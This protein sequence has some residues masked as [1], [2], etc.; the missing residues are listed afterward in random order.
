MT[1]ALATAGSTSSQGMCTLPTNER[2]ANVV[3]QAEASLFVPSKDVEAMFGIRLNRP[4]A[5]SARPAHGG[6]DQAGKEGK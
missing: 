2:A 1:K 6:I 3:P 5:V 4:A